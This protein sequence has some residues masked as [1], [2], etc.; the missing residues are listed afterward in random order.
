[1]EAAV[2]FVDEQ[3]RGPY[4]LWRHEHTFEERD[5]RTIARDQVDYSVRG[6]R[7]INWLL[8]ENDVRRIF[9]FRQQALSEYFGENPQLQLN[10]C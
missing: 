2:P 10:P 6:G 5:G 1:M 7:F 9:E 3:I 8:V 4:R